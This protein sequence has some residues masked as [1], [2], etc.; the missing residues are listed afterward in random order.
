[1]HLGR[2]G[3]TAPRLKISIADERFPEAHPKPSPGTVRA[4]DKD[5]NPG[6]EE[7]EA[8]WGSE[9][10][11]GPLSVEDP[12]ALRTAEQQELQRGKA[13]KETTIRPA[14]WT[15]PTCDPR[16]Y[17][18]CTWTQT[19]ADGHDAV[20]EG[21]PVR[22]TS[23]PPQVISACC[24][25]PGLTRDF[26]KRLRMN[27]ALTYSRLVI[28]NSDCLLGLIG[29]GWLSWS[30]SARATSHTTAI[31]RI[32]RIICK[33]QNP[34]TK[35]DRKHHH[36]PSSQGAT[37]TLL[38]LRPAHAPIVSVP[39]AVKRLR[40]R[41]LPSFRYLHW[42]GNPPTSLDFRAMYVW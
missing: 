34:V 10:G 5:A 40:G 13:L 16:C 20:S 41:C 37:I 4:T 7:E 33:P 42:I 28:Q 36:P 19:L 3:S 2:L 6:E 23:C 1:M 8:D 14:K 21:H 12:E 38:G 29:N 27:A 32:S 9:S 31:Y 22:R 39:V 18:A 11:G 15:K 25:N 26:L 35:H 24:L 30:T 17:K